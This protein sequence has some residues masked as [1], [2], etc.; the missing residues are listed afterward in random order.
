MDIIVTSSLRRR[1]A[2]L[3]IHIEGLQYMLV[4]IVSD[5]IHSRI[6]CVS[7]RESETESEREQR[8]AGSR[9]C[10]K[11]QRGCGRETDK[12]RRGERG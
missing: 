9:D 8:A 11:E 4:F 7:K 10:G 3:L 12:E 5:V 2:Q 6:T 1:N